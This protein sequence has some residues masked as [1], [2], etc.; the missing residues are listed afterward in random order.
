MFIMLLAFFIILNSMSNFEEH[1]AKT[2]LNSITIT[3]SDEEVPADIDSNITDDI[4][5]SYHEGD[6]LDRL[7][8]LFKSQI[9]GAKIKKDRLGVT[10]QMR[11]P[12]ETFEAQIMRGQSAE[13]ASG[14]DLKKT[15]VSLLNSGEGVQYRMEI[16][17]NLPQ[18][19][20]K[21]QK[22]QPQYMSGEIER[23]ARYAKV[24]EDAGLPKTYVTP[25]VEEG[26]EGTVTLFFRRYQPFS[27][28]EE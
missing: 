9:S 22:D 4:Q 16:M 5:Q 6:V 25:G 24:L 11:L 14:V 12:L 27:P 21:L 28:I 23:V 13:D 3:F 18:N 10:M 1:V 19:P 8:E 17:L 7:Q 20:S 2:V 15:L 26:P